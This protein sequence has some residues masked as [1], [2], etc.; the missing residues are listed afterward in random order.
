MSDSLTVLAVSAGGGDR[1]ALSEFIRASQS[2]VWRFIAHT[3]GSAAADDLTQE[4]Y[5]RVVVALPGFEARSSALTWL[6]SI[7]RR[8]VVDQIRH[9]RAR[10][11]LVG[12]D[13]ARLAERAD[14]RHH[15]HRIEMAQAIEGLEE[16]RRAAFVLT[17]SMGFTYAEAAEICGCAIGTIRSRVARARADL[18]EAMRP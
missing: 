12:V 17:Q 3:A 11:E 15:E 4:T 10:P 1:A 5:L 2:Q 7:A 13:G 6:L 18:M 8:V 14:G 16:E 9:D